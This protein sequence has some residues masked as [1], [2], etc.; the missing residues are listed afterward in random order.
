MFLC[1]QFDLDFHYIFLESIVNFTPYER[2]IMLRYYDKD[3]GQIEEL[4]F[5]TRD[6]QS[7][8][9]V[10]DFLS[11][12]IIRIKTPNMFL[13][14]QREMY[15]QL[16]KYSLP[17]TIFDY[18]VQMNTS[19]VAKKISIAREEL[20]QSTVDELVNMFQ[21]NLKRLEKL[22][23]VIETGREYIFQREN[24]FVKTYINRLQYPYRVGK[25]LEMSEPLGPR[26]KKAGGDKEPQN[27]L[28][29]EN[30][31]A[32]MDNPFAQF[33]NDELEPEEEPQETASKMP[34][35]QAPTPKSQQ[36]TAQK[37]TVPP[38]APPQ[39]PSE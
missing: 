39:P 4:S 10:M 30:K 24:L 26:P 34:P 9:V 25:K 7:M 36:P 11:Y 35:P 12:C 22:E 37:P 3:R 32:V 31:P 33:I 15:A 17:M 20:S 13:Y 2:H 18:E 29:S 14:L 21:K 16:I 19:I 28:K 23:I 8:W 6:K 1:V 38:P 5:A 27:V